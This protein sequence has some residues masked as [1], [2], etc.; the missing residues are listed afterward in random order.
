MQHW[1]NKYL[2]RSFYVQD[3][4][5][6]DVR[7]GKGTVALSVKVM[8]NQGDRLHTQTEGGRLIGP[9]RSPSV[10]GTEC[11]CMTQG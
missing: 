3:A 9:D 11:R 2:L 10:S 6:V 7:E 1:F 8:F 5:L 4:E